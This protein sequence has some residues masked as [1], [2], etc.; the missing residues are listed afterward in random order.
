SI[1]E[2]PRP[3]QSQIARQTLARGALPTRPPSAGVARWPQVANHTQKTATSCSASHTIARH[4]HDRSGVSQTDRPF[5][6]LSEIPKIESANYYGQRRS[7][8][9]Q[10]S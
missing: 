4:A 5:Q 10:S 7:Y 2:L 6:S 9:P 8:E 1:A 3:T